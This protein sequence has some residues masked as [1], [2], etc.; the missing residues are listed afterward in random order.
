MVHLPVVPVP[1]SKFEVIYNSMVLV[2]VLIFC[3]NNKN[4]FF[5]IFKNIYIFI[6]NFLR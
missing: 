5:L 6:F 2:L 4:I 3:E 1:C